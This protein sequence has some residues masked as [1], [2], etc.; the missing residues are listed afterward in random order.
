MVKE[1]AGFE[2]KEI[3]EEVVKSQFDKT[4][5]LDYIRICLPDY[6]VMVESHNPTVDAFINIAAD[7]G[8]IHVNENDTG[9]EALSIGIYDI[10]TVN[11]P[12]GYGTLAHSQSRKNARLSGRP[13]RL[14]IWKLRKLEKKMA[15]LY[16]SSIEIKSMITDSVKEYNR[17]TKTKRS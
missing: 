11:Y 14:T 15:G 2:V 1:S 12:Y 4:T 9:Y 7:N 13:S 10:W 8:N 16:R 5:I 3:H 17:L 6:W